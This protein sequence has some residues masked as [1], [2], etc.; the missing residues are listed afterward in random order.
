M[1]SNQGGDTSSP[2][3][4]VGTRAGT[5][6]TPANLSNTIFRK[7]S[8]K[9]RD[10]TPSEENKQYDPGGKGEKPPLWNAAVMAFS[11]FLLGGTLSHGR[12]DVCA[13][14]SLSLCACLSIH[15]ILFYQVITVQRA[16]KNRRGNADEVVDVYAT[17]GQAPSCL[18]TP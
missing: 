10:K 6:T 16:E 18:S 1:G 2:T 11:F 7:S 5:A 8:H 9:P 13:S 14:C 3:E 17:G 12:L 4:R 15:Y